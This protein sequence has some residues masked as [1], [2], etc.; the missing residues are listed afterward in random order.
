M[1][2]ILIFVGALIGTLAGL[3]T[4]PSFFM[5]GQLNW[6]NVITKGYFVGPIEGFLGKGMID[7]SFFHVLKFQ[8]A[9]VALAIIILIVMGMIRKSSS[10]KKTK[11]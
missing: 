6:L 8:G 10:P 9:G 4:R 5:I 1:K 2:I 11:K 3:Y 7:E